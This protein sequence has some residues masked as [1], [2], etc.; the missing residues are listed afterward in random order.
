MQESASEEGHLRRQAQA[1]VDRPWP[2]TLEAEVGFPLLSLRFFLLGR[3]LTISAG[4]NEETP[5]C[6]EPVG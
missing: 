1:G 4:S 2:S 3:Q 6:R 5:N